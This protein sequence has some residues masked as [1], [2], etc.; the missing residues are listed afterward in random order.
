MMPG[1][2]GIDLAIR[3]REINPKC[4]VLLFSAKAA[5]ADLLEIARKQGYEFEVL[6]KPVH[7]EDLLAKPQADR[8]E[9]SSTV[10]HLRG[11]F[12][13]RH[14]PTLIPIRMVNFH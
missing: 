1:T 11:L 3:F 6:A 14:C 4:K 13:R 10:P 9:V 2:T 7:P 8:Q 12:F 5:T